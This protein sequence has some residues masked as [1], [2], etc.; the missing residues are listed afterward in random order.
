MN[1]SAK[2]LDVSENNIIPG[3]EDAFYYLWTERKL[4]VNIDPH[5]INLKDTLERKTLMEQLD[6]GLE[7]PAGY[8]LPLQWAYQ[9]N[10]WI[11]CPW[12]FRGGKMMLIPGNSQMG[13]RLP[14]ESLPFI[15]ESKRPKP[16]VRSLFEETEALA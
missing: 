16:A 8:V 13:Y 9:K 7:D 10:N 3:F 14:L 4:P 6:R 11:S 12:E 1:S 15:P 2:I 5:H